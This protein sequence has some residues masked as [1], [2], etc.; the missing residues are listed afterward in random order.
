MKN[1]G[2]KNEL[3]LK[4]SSE[5]S[6]IEEINDELSDDEMDEKYINEKIEKIPEDGIKR[7]GYYFLGI[8]IDQFYKSFKFETKEIESKINFVD[9]D[10]EGVK[11]IC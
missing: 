7:K 9:Y 6:D 1:S 4:N 2:E 8:D 10:D 5:I 11:S 3:I